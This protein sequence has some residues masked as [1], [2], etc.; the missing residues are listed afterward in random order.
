MRENQSGQH[1][2]PRSRRSQINLFRIYLQSRETQE[3]STRQPS[4]PHLPRRK[5]DGQPANQAQARE[6]PKQYGTVSTRKETS[7][8]KFQSRDPGRLPHRVKYQQQDSREEQDWHHRTHKY[9]S[10]AFHLLKTATFSKLSKSPWRKD[11]V[12]EARTDPHRIRNATL[13]RNYYRAH[14]T[15]SEK[16]RRSKRLLEKPSNSQPNQHR[17]SKGQE[18]SQ[19]EIE[20]RKPEPNTKFPHQTN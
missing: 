19:L 18:S 6:S 10:L 11:P 14:Q 20:K 3:F 7:F 1:H 17:G 8:R 15:M 9:D 16:T 5:L 2:Q 12:P 13:G 4:T